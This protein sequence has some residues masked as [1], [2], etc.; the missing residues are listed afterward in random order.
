MC[1]AIEGLLEGEV[2]GFKQE[3]IFAL[4]FRAAVVVML[5]AAIAFVQ[6]QAAMMLMQRALAFLFLSRS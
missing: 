5:P 2:S 3:S 4:L 6:F 1:Q